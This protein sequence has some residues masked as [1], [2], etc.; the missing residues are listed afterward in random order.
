MLVISR[1][2]NEAVIVDEWVVRVTA[3][4]PGVVE[5]T[6]TNRSSGQNWLES[7]KVS[8]T[9]QIEPEVTVA[10]VEIRETSKVRLGFDCPRSRPVM[11]EEVWNLVWDKHDGAEPV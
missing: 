2:L 10:C 5:C 11:R 6:V 3:L 8:E 9:F 4:L 1:G 7:L